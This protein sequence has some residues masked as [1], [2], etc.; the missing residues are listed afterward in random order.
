MNT[1]RWIES[2]VPTGLKVRQVYGFIFNMDG[3]ILL[4]EDEGRYNLPGG[5]PE[6]NEDANETL[7]R[8]LLEEGQLTINSPEYLG[9]QFID[10]DEEYA[11]VRFAALIEQ[12]LP[13]ASDPST[14]RQ[15][16]RLWVPPNQV[17]ELLTWGES[18]NQQ[19]AAATAAASK[20]GAVWN[21]APLEYIAKI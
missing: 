1:Y 17:N 10:G 14:G 16:G 19:L 8:E 20:R 4:L 18:G 9:Y 5:R 11:Q 2:E 15:Y 12:I 13:S 21:G 3:R 6:N 7:A